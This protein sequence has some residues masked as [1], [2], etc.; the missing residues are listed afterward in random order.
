MK[1][2]LFFFAL[3]SQLSCSPSLNDLDDL[4]F[5]EGSWYGNIQGKE[6]IEKWTLEGDSL[7]LGKSYMIDGADTVLSECMS[8]VSRSGK[9]QFIANTNP[10]DSLHETVSFSLMETKEGCFRF[11][12]LFNDFPQN[13]VYCELSKDSLLAYIDGNY[14]GQYNR[15]NFPMKRKK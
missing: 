13:V 1:K 14:Q 2:I 4:N 3:V 9:L 5:L 11:E 7:W 15:I 8:I 12:N 10:K 6:M